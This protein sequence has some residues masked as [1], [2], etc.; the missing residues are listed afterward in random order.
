MKNLLSKILKTKITPKFYL[1]L[2]E[3]PGVYVYFKKGN[4]IY[5]G[6][7]INLKHRV[8]SYFRLNLEAKTARMISEAE[9]LG[10]IK[11]TNELEA[12]LLEAKLIKTYLPKYNIISKDDKH[13]L[14]IVITKEEFPRV[15]SARKLITNNQEIIADYGPFP[16][17]TNVKTV[18][19]MIRRIF[20]Y[21]DHKLGKRACLYSQIG[22]CSP[23]PNEIVHSTKYA[24]LRKEYLSNI[25]HIKAILDGKIENLKREF[26]KEME[27]YS[28]NESY[29]KAGELRDKIRKLTYITSPK[30]S[31]EGYLEN[32]N[33][34]E[35]LRSGEIENLRSL[36]TG[37][38]PVK[39][40]ARI[41]C[42]DVA[43]LQG[44]SATASMV[45]FINGTP[46]KSL[47][48]HFRIIQKN[49]RDDYSSMKELAKRRK[50]H[51]GDWGVP[52]LII[53]D[54]GKGQLSMFLKEYENEG[55]PIVGLAKKFE[56]LV[57]PVKIME[58]NS[59]KEVRLPKSPALNLIERLRDEAH[60]FAQ[61]YHHKLISKELFETKK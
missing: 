37:F 43:H 19:K 6:K 54:G 24:V 51:F 35:D 5:I 53:V 2:P 42:F 48:R 56:T 61:S 15:L 47:Y 41:E 14:Y 10:Y 31:I 38:L 28:K 46:D 60:R 12:L 33:F 13:P 58:A 7:A 27:R 45:T 50:K 3:N 40:L 16:S 20:P 34:S 57:I 32:P 17:S 39:N 26:T 44:A 30:A 25:R 59:Y 11:V 36:L 22:L 1:K 8:A 23:C 55:I 4:P 29:E 18:L 52:D 21:S 9:E 49:R